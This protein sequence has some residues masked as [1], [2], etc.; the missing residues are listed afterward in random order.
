LNIPASPISTATPAALPGAGRPSPAGALRLVPLD[1][2][3]APALVEAVL[4]IAR[5]PHG[6]SLWWV[7]PGYSLAEAHAFIA[8]AMLLQEQNL[9]D[10]FAIEEQGVLLGLANA[11]SYDWVHGCFQGGYWLRP[12]ARGRGAATEA[13]RQL[14][15]LEHARGM[16]RMELLIGHDNARSAAVAQRVGAQF[17]GRLRNRLIVNDVRKD[18]AL[19]ALWLPS[20]GLS[21]AAMAAGRTSTQG[22]G[23]V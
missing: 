5:D 3:H 4:E 23:D 12:S 11:K 10:V 9:G 17:E 1:P 20:L 2:A 8:R 7:H 13:L 19:W 22:N 6:H 15:L 16:L 21:M 18:A 14:A